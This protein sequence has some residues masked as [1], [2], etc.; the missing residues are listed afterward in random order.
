VKS[1]AA[2]ALH[3]RTVRIVESLDT[4]RAGAD[5]HR[6]RDRM[7]IV[8]GLDIHG[9]AAAAT[10]RVRRTLPIFD[11][12]IDRQRGMVTPCVVAGLGREEVPVIPMPVRPDA[13]V[14][15][16]ATAQ[17]ATHVECNGPAV[18]ARVRN[19]REAPISLTPE[20]QEPLPWFD[21]FRHV[22]IAARLEEEHG[23]GSVLGQPAR[24]DGAGRTRAT[25]DEVVVRLQ[26][27]SECCLIAPNAFCKLCRGRAGGEIVAHVNSPS[28]GEIARG[29]GS[30]ATSIAP[31]G[32]RS[33]HFDEERRWPIRSDT[34]FRTKAKV[35]KWRRIA[36]ATRPLRIRGSSGAGRGR[37]TLSRGRRD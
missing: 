30:L 5:E 11:A 22:I 34:S 27:G 26:V 28:C 31:R 35:A 1:R 29:V 12:P 9:S 8:R 23:H 33:D 17:H 21:D 37:N 10:L 7:G 19:R 4:A 14:D 2:A 24:N 32:R 13:R 3:H 20:V 15:A 6:E 36:A 16:R 18:E 25:D